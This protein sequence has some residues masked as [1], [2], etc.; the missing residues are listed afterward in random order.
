[1]PT[2]KFASIARRKISEKL[3]NSLSHLDSSPNELPDI[4]PITK[5]MPMKGQSSIKRRQDVKPKRLP[6]SNRRKLSKPKREKP[7]WMSKRVID[8]LF[9]FNTVAFT[10]QEYCNGLKTVFKLFKYCICFIHKLK[11]L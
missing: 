10:K 1:M 8:E 2:N 11:A 5:L 9:K 4:K 7:K 3:S 6:S